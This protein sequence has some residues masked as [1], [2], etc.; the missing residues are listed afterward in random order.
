ME[1]PLPGFAVRETFVRPTSQHEHISSNDSGAN[2][3]HTI[4]QGRPTHKS[5]ASLSSF[6]RLGME[7]SQQSQ[8]DRQG[9]SN[10]EPSDQQEDKDTE[11]AEHSDQQGD[12]GTEHAEPSDQQGDKNTGR[13]QGSATT[14]EGNDE[15]NNE[16]E[17]DSGPPTGTYSTSTE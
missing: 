10:A 12:K 13:N 4:P 15:G 8:L 2:P 5:S 9:K 11:H 1:D 16:G 17:T 14:S 3:T 7:E 6:S